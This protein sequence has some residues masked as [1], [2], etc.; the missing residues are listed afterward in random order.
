MNIRILGCSGSIARDCRTTSFLLD[1]DVLIDAGTGVGDL[2]LDEL[3]RIDHILLSHSHLDHVL[4]VPLLA[5]SV[6][7]RRAGRAPIQVH[8]LPE[9]LQVLRQHLFNDLLWPDFTRLPTVAKPVLQL[10]PL[11][12]GEQLTLGAA[13]RPIEVL[14]ASH[15]V[16]ACGYAVR[17][18]SGQ[19]WV[20]TGDTG[21]NPALWRALQGR[22]IG[23][24]VIEV[25][26]AE[27]DR[28]V[29]A[30]S[31]HHCPST[32]ASELSHVPAGAQILL[33]HIKPGEL[34][35]IRSELAERLPALA[36]EALHAGR[37]L[38]MD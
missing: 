5:D 27:A 4:G 33:T 35:T 16:P 12:I 28:T 13:R 29:A 18:P 2:T 11:A 20:Y 8:A 36:F 34:E 21:P 38:Q 19:S 32:L 9:T 14:P 15:A 37:T 31:R 30:D 24:L 23:Q 25:A 3:A 6:M 22:R 26:F 7:R 17:A 1:D 10:Q